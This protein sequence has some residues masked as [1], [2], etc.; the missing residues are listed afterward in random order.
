MNKQPRV[1]SAKPNTNNRNSNQ[2]IG[3]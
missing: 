3:E 2:T 1:L